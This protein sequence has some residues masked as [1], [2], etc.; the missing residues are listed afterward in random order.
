M[1]TS[2]HR[3]INTLISLLQPAGQSSVMRYKRF[4]EDFG[5]GDAP[6]PA[7][8]KVPRPADFLATFAGNTDDAF[9]VGLQVRGVRSGQVRGV[10]RGCRA[11]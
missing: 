2:F 4:V 10:W 3:I 8:G 11:G 9:R 6:P 5:D 7:P 1:P